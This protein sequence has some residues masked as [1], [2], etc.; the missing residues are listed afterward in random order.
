[1]SDDSTL[2]PLA[3][4]IR[5]AGIAAWEESETA[6]REALAQHLN[7]AFLGSASAGKDSAMRALFGLDFGDVSPI[8]GSTDRIKVAPLDA[9]GQVLLVNAPGFG[10]IRAEVDAAA[11][12][13]LDSLDIVVYV[14]NCEGGATIDERRDL[15]AIRALDRPVL[16]ALNKIDL[17]RPAQRDAFIAATLDQLGVAPKDAAICAFDPLPQLAL[18]PIGLERVIA[19]IHE[20]LEKSGKEL[21]FA[22]QLRNKAA[23]CE[24]IVMAAARN[25]SMAG[26]VPIPGADLAVVTAI[27]VKL[28]RDVAEVFEAPVDRDVAL[29]ILGEVLAGGMKG[30]VRWGMQA[31]KAAGWIPGG[32]LAEGAIVAVSALIAGGTTYGVGRAAVHFFQ[33]GRKLEGDALRMV[34]D[35]AAFE[36]KRRKDAAGS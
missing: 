4:E 24:P 6:L 34:F 27:Q 12:K 17:I 5:Q 10:D 2:D 30:F 20:Q 14:V 13:A 28:I 33:S 7:V 36:Y 16:V 19:W 25:A 1:M 31:L 22:K 32:Q 26:A 9:E 21:L 11:R 35:A 18:E 15:D 3:L 23:A 29:F 8:P